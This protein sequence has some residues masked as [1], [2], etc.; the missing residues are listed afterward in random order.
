MLR[1]GNLITT[2][3]ILL[4]EYT[5]CFAPAKRLAVKIVYVMNSSVSN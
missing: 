5:E 4:V 2:S 1:F 3:Q